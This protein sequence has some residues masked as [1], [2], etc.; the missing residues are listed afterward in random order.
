VSKNDVTVQNVGHKPQKCQ[1]YIVG[2]KPSIHKRD[3]KMGAPT[4]MMSST[5]LRS[6]PI[7]PTI[8][9]YGVG[10]TPEQLDPCPG[11]SY[12]MRLHRWWQ[13]LDLCHGHATGEGCQVPLY[14]PQYSL[15]S[16]DDGPT[17][18]CGSSW[19]GS[20]LEDDA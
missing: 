3:T 7:G 19:L 8:M 12:Y 9:H 18:A 20:S 14:P 16:V 15:T 1:V 4:R 17:S 5:N 6:R 10:Q 2:L 13:I 11:Y